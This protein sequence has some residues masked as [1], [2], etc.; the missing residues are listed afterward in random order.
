MN[1]E[2]VFKII[3]KEEWQNAKKTGTYSGSDN[4]KKDGYIHFSEE[5]QVPETLKK[6]YP[7][8]QRKSHKSRPGPRKSH[9]SR[10]G[11]R[12]KSNR[13]THSNKRRVK[14]GN[15]RTHQPF[16]PKKVVR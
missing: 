16:Y 13:R 6:H 15:E 2:F 1:L 3:E 9:K 14:G 4:D 7:N 5:D 12:K 11:L 8:K 10:G